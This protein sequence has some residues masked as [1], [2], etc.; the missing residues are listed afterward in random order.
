LAS[1]LLVVLLASSVGTVLGLVAGIG[2]RWVDEGIMRIADM[3]LAFPYLILAMAIVAAL[4]PGLQNA[5]IAV[6]ITWWPGYA[7]LIR[8]Q[9]LSLKG[10]AYVDAARVAGAGT[11]RL[12]LRHLLPNTMSPLLVKMTSDVGFAILSTASLGFVGLG[13]RPP[14]PEWGAML[15]SGRAYLIDHW[16]LATF[17]GLAIFLTV[18]GFGLLGDGLRD[19]LD[20]RLRRS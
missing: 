14:S 11:P 2:S 17:P 12:L 8:G 7:R 9:I 6:A 19:I 20:P 1:G 16:W 4:G 10:L 18:F 3:F 5:M 13:A 15:A